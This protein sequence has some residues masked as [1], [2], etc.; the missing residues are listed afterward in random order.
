MRKNILI[1]GRP[2]VGKTTLIKHC[3]K[4]LGDRAGGFYTEEIRGDGVRGRRGFSLTTLD[5]MHGVLAEV[6]AHSTYHVG[7]YG[8][9]LDVMD[10]IA[11]PALRDA[12]E[13]KEWILV[14]EIGKME[15]GSVLFKKTLLEALDSSK[16]VLAAIR[17]RDS[18]Y[19]KVIKQRDDVQIIKLTV[20][21]REFITQEIMKIIDTLS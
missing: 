11:V 1:T 17:W 2:R 3:A 9:H 4:I 20:P 6:D 15:E 14:D 8:V 12:I 13:N 19:I 16:H 5:G 21:D 7:R 18:V 10:A